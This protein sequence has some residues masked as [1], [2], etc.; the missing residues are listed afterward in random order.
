MLPKYSK[1]QS[2]VWWEMERILNECATCCPK[3]SP[4][5]QKIVQLFQDAKHFQLTGL[6]IPFSVNQSTTVECHDKLVAAATIPLNKTFL[7]MLLTVLITN[8][9]V[10][11]SRNVMEVEPV[12]QTNQR[13][14]SYLAK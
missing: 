11:Q 12:S 3:N 14:R 13:N 6:D 10:G 5:V 2:T 4:K 9:F 1:L 8:L 7:M